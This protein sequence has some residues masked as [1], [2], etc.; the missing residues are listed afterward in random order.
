MR[1]M[2]SDTWKR[3]GYAAFMVS[4][5]WNAT[6]GPTRAIRLNGDIGRPSGLL[7]RSA[8]SSGVPSSTAL[9]TSPM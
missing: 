7:A 8:T 5:T 9:M 3:S 1:R 2:F 4:D 6:A